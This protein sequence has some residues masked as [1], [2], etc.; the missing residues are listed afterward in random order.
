VCKIAW[1]AIEPGT[2]RQGDFAHAVNASEKRIYPAFDSWT[3]LSRHHGIMGREPDG[4]RK[5]ALDA[6]PG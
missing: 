6:V 3:L 5:I 1:P 4:V 2:V